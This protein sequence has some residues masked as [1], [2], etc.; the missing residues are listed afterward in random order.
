MLAF[1][2]LDLKSRP[3]DSEP[4]ADYIPPMRCRLTANYT[5][6]LYPSTPPQ[7]LLTEADDESSN[8]AHPELSPNDPTAV[9]E[10]P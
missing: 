4:F 9:I 7:L 3:S 1:S 6:L 2:S 5:A 10:L 8:R